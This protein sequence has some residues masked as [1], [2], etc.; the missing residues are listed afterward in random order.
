MAA[1]HPPAVL[2]RLL[3]PVAR[4][5]TPDGARRLVNL[6]ADPVVQG[7]ID[8]L[9]DRC[10]AGQL[11]AEEQSEYETYVSFIAFI[12]LLQAKARRRLA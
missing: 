10:T 9:A 3:D 2:D 7:R 12:G 4:C 1:Q 8:D 11:T 6:R 5:L